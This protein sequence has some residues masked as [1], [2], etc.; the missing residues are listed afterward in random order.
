[1]PDPVDPVAGPPGPGDQRVRAVPAAP[2]DAR[3]GRRAEMTR[4]AVAAA[5]EVARTHGLRVVEPV[6]LADQFSVQVHLT[7]APVAGVSTW[8]AV[9][10]PD[11]CPGSPGRWP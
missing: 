2:P 5:L 4:R 6:V 7:P 8:T 1:V 11:P 10:R 9:V 3:P